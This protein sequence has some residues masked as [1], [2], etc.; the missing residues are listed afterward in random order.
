MKRIL[1]VLLAAVLLC[2]AVAAFADAYPLKRGSR[3]E[4]VESLQL[5]LFDLGFLADEPDG[6]FGRK[7]EA[8]VKAW[9]KYSG[10]KQTGQMNEEAIG[11]LDE[12]WTTTEGIASEANATE[13]EMKEWFGFYCTVTP[14]DDGV[15]QYGYCYRHYRMTGLAE[16]LEQ[17]GMPAKMERKLAE[18]LRDLWLRDIP[19][20]Y[21]EMELVDQEQAQEERQIYEEGLAEMREVWAGQVSAADPNAD[22]VAEALWL[23]ATGVDLCNILHWGEDNIP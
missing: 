18:R 17:G 15:D 10:V 20:L 5:M 4:E 16:K 2:L 22:V 7:T 8:A 1:S 19:L 21:D 12:V 23:N 3:G 14:Q 13:E 9:Q 11:A 6:I